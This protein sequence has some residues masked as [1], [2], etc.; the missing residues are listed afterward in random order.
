M[1]TNNVYKTFK[2][3][4]F[5]K[6]GQKYNSAGQHSDKA[7]LGSEFWTEDRE[8][9]FDG[10]VW[11]NGHHSDASSIVNAFPKWWTVIEI[12]W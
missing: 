9:P 2:R 4:T 8:R 5:T 10:L 3:K 7:D 1:F 11:T 6:N 12:Y